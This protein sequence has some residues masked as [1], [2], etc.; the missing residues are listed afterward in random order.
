MTSNSQFAVAIHVLSV[1]GVLQKMGEERVSSR[2]I[3]MS[4]NTNPVVIRNLVALLKESGLVDSKEG[5]GGGLKL[6]KSPGKISLQDIYISVA[7]GESVLT[8]NKRAEI[9]SCPVSCGMKKVLPT[10][11]EE[12]DRAVEKSLKGK[13]LLSVMEKVIHESTT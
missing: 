1:L 3:A 4:V 7:H 9:K 8:L 5:K 6:A 13:T 12:V 2:Q 11:F 10:I